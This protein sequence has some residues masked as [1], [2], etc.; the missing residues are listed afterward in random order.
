MG[1]ENSPQKSNF[2]QS[3]RLDGTGDV[4]GTQA[5]DTVSVA[6]LPVRNQAFGAI[7]TESSDFFGYPISG[8]MGLGF[9]SIATVGTPFMENLVRRFVPAPPAVAS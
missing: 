5:Y 4:S 9:K 8:L 1:S 3:R 7:V 2:L 6:G